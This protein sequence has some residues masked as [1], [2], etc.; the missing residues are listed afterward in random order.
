MI[1]RDEVLGRTHWPD[2]VVKHYHLK[3]FIRVDRDDLRRLGGDLPNYLLLTSAPTK[4]ARTF[5]EVIKEMQ[6]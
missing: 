2:A 3:G 5:E 4:D 1:V 6:K